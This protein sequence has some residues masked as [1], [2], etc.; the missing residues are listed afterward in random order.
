M[1]QDDNVDSYF[2]TMVDLHHLPPDFPGLPERRSRADP[3]SKVE[4]LEQ[5]LGEDIQHGRFIPYIQLQEFEA[6]LFTDPA[7]LAHAFPVRTRA[8]EDLELTRRRFPSPEHI[9]EGSETAP[10]KRIAAVIPEYAGAKPSAGPLVAERI[11]LAKLREK[12][13]HFDSWCRRLESLGG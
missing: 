10:S 3:V 5:R 1:R 2:T 12:C 4:C 11:G 7:Q 6:L 8:A 9:D 13:R